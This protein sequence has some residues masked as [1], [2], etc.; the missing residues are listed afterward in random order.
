LLRYFILSGEGVEIWPKGERDKAVWL[1]APQGRVDLPMNS[2]HKWTIRIPAGTELGTDIVAWQYVDDG[3]MEAIMAW[4]RSKGTMP[5]P[6]FDGA[7][8][9]S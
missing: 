7:S 3:K 4:A 2:T 9:K 8:K 6:K 1:P 5:F